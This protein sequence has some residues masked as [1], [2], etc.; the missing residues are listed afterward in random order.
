MEDSMYKD[1]ECMEE[2]EKRSGIKSERSSK[3]ADLSR[4]EDM[5]EKRV[6]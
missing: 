4:K 6:T 1:K 3:I 2:G 5:Y